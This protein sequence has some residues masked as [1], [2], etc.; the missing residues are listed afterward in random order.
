MTPL[1]S[2]NLASPPRSRNSA[3]NVFPRLGRVL[4]SLRP[5]ETGAELIEFLA[6]WTQDHAYGPRAEME[7]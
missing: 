6:E 2:A 3:T 7:G 1:M 4:L 5:D